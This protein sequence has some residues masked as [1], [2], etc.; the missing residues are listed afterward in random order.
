[1]TR[2][3]PSSDIDQR[4]SL[5]FLKTCDL[6][7]VSIESLNENL[8]TLLTGQSINTLR[9]NPGLVLYRGII[10]ATKP[11]TYPDLIYPPIDKAKQNRASMEGE[12]MFY[13]SNIKKAPFY[14][15]CAQ[16]G[17]RLVLSTWYLRRE[18]TFNNIGYT[19]RNLETFESD[20]KFS[21][22]EVL[23]DVIATE[24]GAIF[25]KGVT[26]DESIYYKLTNAIAKKYLFA[27]VLTKDYK[28]TPLF[29]QS[30]SSYNE[31]TDSNV[32]QEFPG[33][34]Y[35]TIRNDGIGD[36]FAIKKEAIDDDILELHRVEYVEIV[37]IKDN[38][39]EY[40]ILD[41]A[42]DINDSKINW[43]NVDRH[44]RVFDDAD[45]INICHEDEEFEAFTSDGDLIEPE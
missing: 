29:A 7:T 45:E 32:A 9:Y 26:Q 24:L 17:D 36:N 8:K 33:L 19:K 30:D 16:K 21:T 31:E 42:S 37:D 18:S 25:C 20:R 10:F 12:Q 4:K 43:L 23:D 2:I 34:V 44:W 6:T 35:P 14:E 28:V 11:E 3:I 5:E 38:R 39:Y 13:C 15:L 1:M 22:V 40:K 41:F 27:D